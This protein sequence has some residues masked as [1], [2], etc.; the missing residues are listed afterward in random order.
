ML[1]IHCSF[2]WAALIVL[3]C[4]HRVSHL[5]FMPE[6]AWHYMEEG[7]THVEEG[8]THEKVSEM[9]WSDLRQ[10][11]FLMSCWC[12]TGSSWPAIGLV[13]LHPLSW[14]LPGLAAV[15]S[16]PLHLLWDQSPFARRHLS[17]SSAIK[18]KLHALLWKALRERRI[19]QQFWGHC[20]KSKIAL[21]A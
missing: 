2:W 9:T 20:T 19:L 3:M 15:L 11:I 4:F 1:E 8:N 14:L 21:C 7:N 6:S 17:S 12:E 5:A 18:E 13:E 10:Q 16:C